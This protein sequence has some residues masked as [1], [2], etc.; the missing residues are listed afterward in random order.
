[1][2]ITLTT[3]AGSKQF[4][5]SKVARCIAFAVFLLIVLYFFVSNFLLVKTTDNLNELVQ[6]HQYLN[7][8][9]NELLGTQQKYERELIQLSDV[10]DKVIRQR[11]KLALENGRIEI[12]NDT[13]SAM[14]DERDK[15]KVDSGSISALKSSLSQTELERDKLQVENIKIEKINA[16]LDKNLTA[17]DKSLDELERVLNFQLPASSSQDRFERLAILTKQRIFLL[18]SIPNGLPIKAI[19]VSDGFG[20]RYHPIKKV[21]TMHRGID[22]KAVRGTAVYAPADGVVSA[23]ERRNGSGKYIKISHNFGFETSYSHLN[24][25]LVKVGE[26]VHKGQKIAESGNTG[27]STGPHLHYELLYLSKAIDPADFTA[28]NI[29][30]FEKIFTKVETVKWASLKNL[31]PLNQSV[32]R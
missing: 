24:K 20:M 15:L 19:K 29:A 18:N 21:R 2:V 17:L 7:G 6:D 14:T 28:W 13:L 16:S 11:D 31:Y 3:G 32:P 12:L 5:M 23:V 27:Q 22:Y 10:F 26:Y 4:S 8:Q 25:Y 9:Y 30:N 1:M